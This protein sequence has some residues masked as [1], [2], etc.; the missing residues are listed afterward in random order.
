MTPQ[1]I[2]DQARILVR[3]AALANVILTI[4]QVPLYPLAMGHQ[5]TVVEFRPVID[6]TKG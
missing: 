6:R 2:E 3:Q 1:Q 4:R 5:M